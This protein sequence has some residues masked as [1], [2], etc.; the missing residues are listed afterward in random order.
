MPKNKNT[1]AQ[2]DMDPW[3]EAAIEQN[4]RWLSAYVLSLTGDRTLVDDLVQEV[5]LVAF[6]KKGSFEPGTNFGGWLRG[7]A[8]NMV[9]RYW[10]K[11]GRQ[12]LLSQ[13]AAMER[14]DQIASQAEQR[15]VAPDWTERLKRFLE[16]CIVDLSEK[17]Q[18]M[19]ELRYREGKSSAEVASA[20]G[21]SVST[22]NVTVFR[23][24]AALAEC[25]RRKSTS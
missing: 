7:I 6:Q 14:L 17:A 2:V 12:P 22:V 24:R 21:Q 5:F 23:A 18:K 13:D 1:D 4:R 9:Q 25:M 15:S 20:L 8:R 11:L 3:S 19:L 16:E 10:Q